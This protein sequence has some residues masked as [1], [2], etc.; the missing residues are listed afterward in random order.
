MKT[1]PDGRPTG[2]IMDTKLLHGV[3]L[4]ESLDERETQLIASEVELRQEQ[5]G[6]VI[7][8]EGE[9]SNSLFIVLSGKVKIFLVDE[10]GEEIILNYLGQG[11]YFGE[12]SLFDDGQRSASVK[13]LSD[14][15]L[16][17]LEKDAFVALMSSHPELALRII[18]G[19][20]RRVRDLSSNVRSL[21]A[22]W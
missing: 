1:S 5:Q 16:A 7:I 15:Y 3:P 10:A 6:N 17:V 9:E 22:N 19:S 18:K 20:T 21:A 11:D 8:H 2:N 12:V 13:A 14:C 4:F